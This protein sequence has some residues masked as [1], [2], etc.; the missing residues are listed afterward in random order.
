MTLVTCVS[1]AP[2]LQIKSTWGQTDL[3]WITRDKFSFLVA[4]FKIFTNTAI[5][6]HIV[7]FTRILPAFEWLFHDSS[8]FLIEI[9]NL[10]WIIHHFYSNFP[11]FFAQRDLRAAWV[12]RRGLRVVVACLREVGL[13]V[14][15][16]AAAWGVSVDF[17]TS[18]GFRLIEIRSFNFC[19]VYYHFN[20]HH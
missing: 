6:L 15:R 10:L 3:I 7:T 1:R 5:A 4:V 2:P 20:F 18:V 19:W 17:A 13:V 11:E 9:L 16:S 14:N 12:G 8:K